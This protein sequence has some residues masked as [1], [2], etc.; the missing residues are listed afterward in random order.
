MLD[1]GGWY[2]NGDKEKNFKQIVKCI[3]V[4]AMGPPGGGRSFVT[5]RLVRHLSMISLATFDDDTLNRIFGTILKWFF[6]NNGFPQDIIK[7]E[8]KIV[9]GTLEMYKMA[10]KE[11]LPT[12]TKS[13]YL[14]NL[15]DFAKVIM[16]ICLS[17]KEKVN[18]TDVLA[19]L[20]THEVWRVF[21]DRLINEEDRGLMLRTLREVM[22]KSF[23]LNFDTIF[24]HLDK[25]EA[26]GKKDNKVD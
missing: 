16:G 7:L 17:D 5:P 15:R 10:M 9:N 12:P 11:L 23:G 13:H 24:E 3:F 22:R 21:A 6:G 19:R 8:S 26:D 20:W 2:D 18:T 1:Q 25:V 14:F 4:S